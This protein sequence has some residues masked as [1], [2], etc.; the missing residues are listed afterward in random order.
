MVFTSYAPPSESRPLST[1]LSPC[2]RHSQADLSYRASSY[3]GST[4]HPVR[5]LGQHNGRV[6]GGAARTSRASLRPWEMVCIVSG[7]P[8][9]IA[10]LQLEWALQNP[11]LSRHIDSDKRISFAVTRVKT[12]AKTGKTRRKP[13]RPSTSLLQKLSNLHLLL[14]A[15]YFSQ[16]PLEIRFFSQDVYHSWQSWCE[17]VDEQLHPSIRVILDLP[18]S[19]ATDPEEVTSGQRPAKRRKLDLIGK[20]GIDGIDPTYA[21]MR[22]VLQKG[23]F[24]L[25]EDDSQHCAVCSKPLDLGHDLF[26][27]CSGSDCQSLAHVTCMS[28]HFLQFSSGGAILPK[29]GTCPSCQT[30]LRWLDLMQEL[31]LR[32][33]G[34]KEVSK[35]LSKHKKSTT[36][37]AASVLETDSEDDVEDDF[38]DAAD[39]ADCGEDDELDEQDDDARSVTSIESFSSVIS[40]ALPKSQ[41][42]DKLE[43]VIEDSDDDRG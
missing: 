37:T 21:Q 9:N 11:H 18:Q 6:K 33:R 39:A 24:V 1:I 38:L 40:K 19:P 32:L 7:F 35:I 3:I 15:P 30:D 8:S 34:Q 36:T 23:R 41:N 31:S 42:D 22:D 29:S 25:D 13:G 14:R 16:W 5:R 26:T 2:A 4:P 12:N 27:I 43:I 28:K 10:A 17:R 20:G